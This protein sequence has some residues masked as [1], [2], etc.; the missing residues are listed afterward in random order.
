MTYLQKRFKK[1]END[2]R[3]KYGKFKIMPFKME[4]KTVTGFNLKTGKIIFKK[5]R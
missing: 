4:G 3:R 1:V 2:L 5:G